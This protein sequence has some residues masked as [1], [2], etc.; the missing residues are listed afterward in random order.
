M[1]ANTN[2]GYNYCVREKWEAEFLPDMSVVV[3]EAE[4]KG[5][6]REGTETV[7]KEPVEDSATIEKHK[8][9]GG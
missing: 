5:T 6:E 1:V 4:D 7:V 9:D 2:N 3:V 8:T